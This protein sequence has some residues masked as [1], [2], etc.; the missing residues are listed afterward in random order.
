[1]AGGKLE[2]KMVVASNTVWTA[3]SIRVIG[4]TGKWF[5]IVAGFEPKLGGN[6]DIKQ[7]LYNY[8]NLIV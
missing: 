8:I 4:V 6:Y 7:H 2:R 1:M 3:P 5:R